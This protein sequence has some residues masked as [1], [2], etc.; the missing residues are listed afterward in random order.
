MASLTEIIEESTLFDGPRITGPSKVK[1][2]GVDP[3][4][5]RQINF[6]LMDQVL[7][8]LNNVAD[9]LRPFILMAW[10][11]RRARVI[12]KAGGKGGAPDQDLR[13]FVDRIE[14]IFAWSQFLD[15]PEA[16]IP[17]G[18]ALA[19]LLDPSTSS[20]R[21]GGK[22]WESRRNLR[23]TSTGLI[24]PLNYGPGLRSMGWLAPT[25]AVGVF[26]TNPEL[27]AALDAFEASFA[28]ELD[29]PA[30]SKLGDR[31]SVV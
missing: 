17:G 22:T 9:L 7:P 6:D 31:K 21:F 13:D 2:G 12:V 20:Y 4:G 1:P 26:V 30:F 25:D 24:S 18:Q 5:L 29:H 14:A 11:W 23:R 15:D 10:A 3:L 27:D 16:G 28:D 8:G 19:A